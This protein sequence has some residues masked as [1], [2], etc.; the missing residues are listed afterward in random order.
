M[1]NQNQ[2]KQN[3]TRDYNNKQNNTSETQKHNQ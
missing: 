2:T 1:Q 3:E